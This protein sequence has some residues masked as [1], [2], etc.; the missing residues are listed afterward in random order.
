MPEMLAVKL[1]SII[2]G[3]SGRGEATKS[4]VVGVR[5]E[6]SELVDARCISVGMI[7]LLCKPITAA[8]MH[9][10]FYSMGSRF[11]TQLAS[12]QNGRLDAPTF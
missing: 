8:Q 1:T 6:V 10:L 12:P 9:H 7:D 5:A 2:L 11:A 3:G 4:L